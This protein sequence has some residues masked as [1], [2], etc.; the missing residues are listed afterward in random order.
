M[1]KK[2]SHHI[3]LAIKYYYHA[4]IRV[5]WCRLK[6]HILYI[7]YLQ[8]ILLLLLPIECVYL[9]RGRNDDDDENTKK[10]RPMRRYSYLRGHVYVC[11]R[12]GS[13][14]ITTR[15]CVCVRALCINRTKLNSRLKCQR[16]QL[17]NTK[18]WRPPLLNN[19][20]CTNNTKTSNWNW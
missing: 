16:I 10:I 7:F 2:K 15:Y 20:D 13:K 12:C 1:K 4:E 5:L 17:N 14:R 9:Q 19:N 8:I 18:K 3:F 11:F 6:W